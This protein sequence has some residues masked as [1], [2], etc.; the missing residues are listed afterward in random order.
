MRKGEFPLAS[1]S[2]AAC[3]IDACHLEVRTLK[4]GNVHIYSEGHRMTV[5]QFD[6]SANISAPYISDEKLSVGMRIRKS[7][8]ATLK[9]V[10]T[11][12]NLGILLLCAPLAAAAGPLG[13]G[14][15]LEKRLICILS[16][17]SHEDASEVFIAI[18]QAHPA[19]LGTVE[20]GDVANA[21]PSEWTLGDAMVASAQGDLIAREYAE[22]F[23]HIIENARHYCHTLQEGIQR[24]DAL[25]YVFLKNLALFPDTHIA[26]KHGSS[27]AAWV[28]TRAQ[29]VLMDLNLQ[30]VHDI[31]SF[32]SKQILLSFDKELKNK[33]YNPGSLAD[34]MCASVFY[35]NLCQAE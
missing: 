15:T 11:N 6:D 24:D 7:V 28:H 5:A 4:P 8:D 32:R 16:Q 18:K 23:S 22:N 33:G 30:R 29:Q 25:S 9:A 17:L 12:T 35:F 2:I 3:Y 34:L 21:P 10:Q 31:S 13:S 20:K 14:T 1:A 27:I 26:R 19:G